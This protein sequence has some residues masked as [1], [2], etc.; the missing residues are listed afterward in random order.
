MMIKNHKLEIVDI[1]GHIID[2]VLLS[3]KRTL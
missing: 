1:D 2:K 3:T